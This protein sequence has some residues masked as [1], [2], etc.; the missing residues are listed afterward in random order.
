MVDEKSKELITNALLSMGVQGDVK[1]VQ[2]EFHRHKV[3]VN[4]KYFG[5]FD[6]DKKTFVD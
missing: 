3:L 2:V 1:I 6:I 4:G 5:I